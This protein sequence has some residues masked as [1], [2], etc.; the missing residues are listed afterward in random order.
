MTRGQFIHKQCNLT[1]PTHIDERQELVSLLEN[2]LTSHAL[3]L[4]FFSFDRLNNQ[5]IYIACRFDINTGNTLLN[6]IILLNFKLKMQS[7]KTV[8]LLIVLVTFSIMT[9]DVVQG[10]G[11]SRSCFQSFLIQ[12]FFIVSIH[13]TARWRIK[14]VRPRLLVTRDILILMQKYSD[15]ELVEVIQ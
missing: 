13:S 1:N 14:G 15:N 4:F 12:P 5:D 10:Q 8:C 7:K 9:I 2:I 6:C 3:F 11:Q